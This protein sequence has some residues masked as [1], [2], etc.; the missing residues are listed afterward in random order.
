[1]VDTLASDRSDKPFCEAVLPRRTW[2]DGLV[3]DAHGAQ[4]VRDGSAIDAIPITDHVARRLSP[5]KCFG[6]LACDPVRGRMGCDVDPDKVSAGQPN[7]DKG[8]EQVEANGRNNEQVHGG[9]VRRVVTQEDAPALGRRSTSLDHVL[10]DARLSELKAELEQ[11]AMD[12]RRT[13]QRIVNAHPPDQR[14]QVRVDLGP[15]SK[16]A[17][18]PTPVMAKASPMP[19]HQGL[20]SDDSDG[21]EHRWKPSIQQDQ[22][23]A[24][25]ICELDATPHPALQHNQLMTERR[26]LGLKSALGLERGDGQGQEE[27]EERD[28]RR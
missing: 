25:P 26:V 28:H 10:R 13:P 18:F 20:R 7:D 17:G 22:E 21:P 1:M 6:D 9:D 12:A 8:I 23:Q 4:S 5:R 19:T 2:R 24:I 27:Q 16:G 15:A 3:A 11:L 14:A